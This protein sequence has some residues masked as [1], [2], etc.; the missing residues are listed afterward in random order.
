MR[1]TAI[2]SSIRRRGVAYAL[3]EQTFEHPR[4]TA[5]LGTI[6]QEQAICLFQAYLEHLNLL[7]ATASS[8][9]DQE[10]SRSQQ[11]ARALELA[12]LAVEIC[13]DRNFRHYP[14]A[15]N[16]AGRIVGIGYGD[17]ARDS[18]CSRRGIEQGHAM[19]D[20]WF[21]L[22]NLVEHAELAYRPG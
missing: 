13:R 20:G 22:A 14:S 10:S 15:L 8:A 12:E 16:R 6:Y 7:T 17:F 1:C 4:D 9:G 19:S 2:S 5:W 21:W 3:A 18:V 11:L